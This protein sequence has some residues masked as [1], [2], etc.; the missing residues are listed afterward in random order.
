MHW[1]SIFLNK[2]GFAF[3][4][5]RFRSE[6]D[7]EMAFHRAQ[8]ERELMAAGMAP[9]AA[10]RAATVRFGNAAALRE[11]SHEVIGFRAETVLQDSRFA[12]RQFRKNPGFACTAILILALGMGVSVA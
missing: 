6:L 4:R 3:G 2:L 5:K 1:L 11:H 7:E 12:L 9:E 10:R 8:M